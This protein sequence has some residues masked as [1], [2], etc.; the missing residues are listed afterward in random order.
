MTANATVSHS[1]KAKPSTRRSRRAAFSDL[2]K[3][4]ITLMVVLTTAAGFMLTGSAPWDWM[5]LLHT[6]LGTALVASGAS[7]L[8]QVVERRTDARMKRTANRPIATGQL[9]AKEGLAF[10]VGIAVLGMVYLALA[11]NLLTA[12]LAAATLALY[13]FV[14][15]PMKRI[16]SL[17]TIVGAVPGAMPPMMGCSAASDALGPMAWALFGIL[18]FW[19]MPHFLAIAWLYRSDYQKGGF[20]LL[21]LVSVEGEPSAGS[22]TA[23]QMVLY[24]AALIPVSILPNVLGATGLLYFI[25]AVAMGLLFL[26]YSFGFG[27]RQDARAARHLLLVSVIYLPVVLGLMVVDHLM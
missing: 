5:L 27:Y 22:R 1:P 10:G 9:S 8:N 24:S 11:V 14:Y 17:A 13:V 18:F 3:P 26:V 7:T 23:Q 2:T 6:L 12:T 25:G 19:Q 15:T 21:T 16:S 20:P 4:R